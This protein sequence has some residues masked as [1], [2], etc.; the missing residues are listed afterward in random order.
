MNVFDKHNSSICP[1]WLGTTVSPNLYSQTNGR[2]G[3]PRPVILKREPLGSLS[4]E[5]SIP[6]RKFVPGR[7]WGGKAV[8]EK[9]Q[10]FII[11]L[12]V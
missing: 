8:G 1:Q 3:I 11:R 7:N 5:F 12:F 6:G 10:V 4:E 2:G 9:T